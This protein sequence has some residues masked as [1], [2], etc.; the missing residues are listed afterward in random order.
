MVQ[1]YVDG[2]HAGHLALVPTGSITWSTTGGVATVDASTGEVTAVKAGTGT[3]VATS[4]T[5]AVKASAA[6]TVTP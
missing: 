5:T 6:I 4:K 1:F 2:I 3:V